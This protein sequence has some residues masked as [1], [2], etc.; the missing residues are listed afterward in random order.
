M[1]FHDHGIHVF[2]DLNA[3]VQELDGGEKFPFESLDIPAGCKIGVVEV[4]ETDISGVLSF[5]T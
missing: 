3:V 5:Q 2:N 1:I 4:G